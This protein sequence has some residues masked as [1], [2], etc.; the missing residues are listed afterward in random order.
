MEKNSSM[1]NEDEHL[2]VKY[3]MNELDPS[4]IVMVENAIDEDENLL[5]EIE[6]MRRTWKKLDQLPEFNPPEE[7][8]NNLVSK[9]AAYNSTRRIKYIGLSSKK[10]QVFMAVAAI[11]TA[12]VTLGLANIYNDN[13]SLPAGSEMEV[14]Q[15]ITTES[16][17]ERAEMTPWIDNQN[18]LRLGSPDNNTL[19]A[20][21]AEL[22][23]N[24]QN[25]RLLEDSRIATP[26]SRDFQLTRTSN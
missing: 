13:A 2:C 19:Q 16:H 8:T 26:V 22:L 17:A 25:L 10:T 9:A 18:V 6:S 23:E 7:L 20:T 3:V 4:E 24:M 5:I 11:L 12:T 21:S 14:N 15:V 1:Y